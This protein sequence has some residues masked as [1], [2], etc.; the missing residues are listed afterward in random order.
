[1]RKDVQPFYFFAYPI[2]TIKRVVKNIL[3]Y[4]DMQK[5]KLFGYLAGI[6]IFALV[7]RFLYQL[8]FLIIFIPGTANAIKKTDTLLVYFSD[9][10]KIN[11]QYYDV[12]KL[13]FP[14]MNL[15]LVANSKQFE[16][17]VPYSN[18][19]ADFGYEHVGYDFKA[20]PLN[21][22]H[23]PT[24]SSP[25]YYF[26]DI[27]C[28]KYRSPTYSSRSPGSLNTEFSSYQYFVH[29]LELVSYTKNKFQE[30]NSRTPRLKKEFYDMKVIPMGQLY[31]ASNWIQ[32]VQVAMYLAQSLSITYIETPSIPCEVRQEDT[33]YINEILI[34]NHK[35]KNNNE[36]RENASGKQLK[37]FKHVHIQLTNSDFNIRAINALRNGKHF[38]FYYFNPDNYTFY[39]IDALSFKTVAIQKP[40]RGFQSHRSV[41]KLSRF[42]K[43]CKKT[44]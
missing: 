13:K 3:F 24:P 12:L 30:W 33:I 41:K 7:K 26:F 8:I 18:R 37:Y 38:Y 32:P 23:T 36:V 19:T 17:Y 28:K 42:Q 1:M 11:R 20:L 29:K 40:N 10:Q 39:I 44:N 35:K 31:K 43:N 4:N 16:K 27:S 6:I 34:R 21:Y 5:A 2:F 9:D 15:I 22:G 14:E 25:E